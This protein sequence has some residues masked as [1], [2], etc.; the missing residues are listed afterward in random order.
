LRLAAKKKLSGPAEKELNR[1][2]VGLIRWNDS[3]RSAIGL[4]LFIDGVLAV[5]SGPAT[6]VFGECFIVAQPFIVGT[7]EP[8]RIIRHFLPLFSVK[9]R[10]HKK[11]Y[12]LAITFRVEFSLK[13]AGE[14]CGNRAL[15]QLHLAIIGE[16]ERMDMHDSISFGWRNEIW[17]LC[18]SVKHMQR[19]RLTDPKNSKQPLIRLAGE[20]AVRRMRRKHPMQSGKK[21]VYDGE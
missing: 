3:F 19:T 6:V 9:F 10:I 17:H 15:E 12:C 21:V 5:L 7:F 11:L 20:V 4:F 18:G 8:G 14:L 2:A 16:A 13:R 1:R